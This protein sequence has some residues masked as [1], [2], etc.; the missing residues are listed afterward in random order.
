MVDQLFP[1]GILQ[2][3]ID[4]VL[5]PAYASRY[6]RMMSAINE[7]LLPLGATLP[8]SGPS[9]AGGYFIWVALPG[10]LRANDL[11]P[12]ALQEHRV[13]IA[14]GELFQVQRDLGVTKNEFGSYVR[15][16]FAWEQEEN[17]AEGV[18]RLGYAIRQMTV[19]SESGPRS[20]I[21]LTHGLRELEPR[22]TVE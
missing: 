16:C 21:T 18:R 19:K 4:Q 8:F 20:P 17:L 7:H 13:K 2:T 11:A 9:V 10:S 5:R 15:L 1:Q 12:V 22:V 3:H 14:A 6:H